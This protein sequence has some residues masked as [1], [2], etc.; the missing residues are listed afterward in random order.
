MASARQLLFGKNSLRNRIKRQSVLLDVD[1]QRVDAQTVLLR[2]SL[3]HAT[4]SPVALGAT[5][6]AGF[7][8]GRKK[9]ETTETKTAET[10]QPRSWW[11]ELLVPIAFSWGRDFIVAQLKR[12]VEQK[13][14]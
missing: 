2:H 7:A 9:T 6:A 3:L 12:D 10:N 4:T 14:Q 5:T 13:P 1:L 11:W 8:F